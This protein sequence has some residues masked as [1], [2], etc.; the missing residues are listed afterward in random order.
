[1]LL[2]GDL[3]FKA[4]KKKGNSSPYSVERD[5]LHPSVTLKLTFYDDGPLRHKKSSNNESLKWVLAVFLLFLCSLAGFCSFPSSQ[6][7][8][9]F[10]WYTTRL[11]S[12]GQIN[13]F[14]AVSTTGLLSV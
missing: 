5:T 10:R 14:S 3:T 13:L 12:E 6:M 7:N 4:W 9:S 11:K 8:N 1:M 2:T